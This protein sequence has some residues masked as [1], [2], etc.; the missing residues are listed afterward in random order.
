VTLIAT[1]VAWVLIER[2]AVAP[3]PSPEAAVSS[4]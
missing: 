4:E 3:V 1:I 2:R